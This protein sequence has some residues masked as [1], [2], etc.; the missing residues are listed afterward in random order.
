[1]NRYAILISCEEYEEFENIFYCHADSF[2][3]FETLTEYCDYRKSNVQQK[4]LYKNDQDAAPTVIYKDLQEIVSKV[5]HNDTILFYFA[6]HGMKKDQRGYLLL[7]DT[8]CSHIEDT[9]LSLTRINEILQHSRGP[10]FIILDACHSG[11]LSRGEYISFSVGVI[12]DT[13]CVTLASCSENE[14]SFHYEEKEQGVFTYFLSEAIRSCPLEREI[15]IEQLK[16]S[17]CDAMAKWCVDNYKTQTPTLVGTSIGTSSL[18]TR[19]NKLDKYLPTY[20]LTEVITTNKSTELT[21]SYNTQISYSLW[22]SNIGVQLPKV[23]NVEEILSY[24][25]QLRTTELKAIGM[26]YKAGCFEIA[27]EAIWNRAINIL[28]KRILSFG[29]QFVAEMVG[30]DNLDYVNDLPAFEVINL[31][32]ELGYIDSTGKMRL[33]HANELV[34]HYLQRDISDEMP[35]AESEIV[36]RACIQYVLAF[37]DSNIQV[38]YIDYRNSLKTI[39]FDENRLAALNGCPYFYKK[40]TIRT[41]VNLLSTTENAEFE[42]VDNNFSAIVKAIWGGLTSDDRYF[43]GLSFGKCKNAGDKKQVVA[44]SRALMQVNGFDYVPE[45]L[46]S[47]T[48]ISMAKEIKKT[49][50]AMNN[51]YN[52]PLCVK[53]LNRMGTKIPK[54]AIK[55]C[56]GAVMMVFLGNNYG[57]SF[58]AVEPAMDVLRK[59]SEADWKYYVEECLISDEEVLDKIASGDDRTMRW[60]EIA[61]SFE[62]DHIEYSNGKIQE[63]IRYSVSKDRNNTKAVA[64]AYRKKLW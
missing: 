2:L 18:A 41:L 36:I 6:G 38:E 52:E 17:V 28:R 22:Q 45:N 10:A 55:E 20:D 62:L 60:C 58:E 29:S 39:E 34:Q 49:H 31:A 15:T 61:E 47:L 23:A 51:F 12:Q 21:V 4:V 32:M 30:I 50:Y 25:N 7:P 40:T 56:I 48:F 24:N 43:I 54:P 44:Y 46:R 57:H 5:E 11:I 42:T 3:M 1:M 13:S 19:N 16:L 37:E 59:L 9:S 26:N 64:V 63:F 53:K 33:S 27:S 8:T 35:Q 14:I